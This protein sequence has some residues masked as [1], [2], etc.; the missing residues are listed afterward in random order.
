MFTLLLK[1]SLKVQCICVLLIFFFFFKY[2][3]LI[4]LE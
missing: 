1:G 4:P 2:L 3:T